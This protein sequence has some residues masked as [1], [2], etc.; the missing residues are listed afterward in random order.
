MKTKQMFTALF[1]AMLYIGLHAQ[2][3]TPARIKEYGLGFTGLNNYS[4]QYRWGNE[5]RLKRITGFFAGNSSFG[6]QDYVT[7]T[8]SGSTTTSS[9]KVKAPLQTS[10]GLG[11]SILNLKAVVD[12]FGFMYGPSFS[13]SGGYN[14]G[15]DTQPNYYYNNGV[16][17]TTKGKTSY[18]TGNVDIG[19]V[20]GLYYKVSDNFLVYAEISPSVFF[21]YTQQKSEY[22]YYLYNNNTGN[23]ELLK[24]TS[25]TNNNSFGFSGLT[26][27]NAM[28]TLAYRIKR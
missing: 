24:N 1:F 3:A 20:L 17:Q 9:T 6:K 26:N 19:A 27:S 14:L 23:N 18:Y 11:F 22:E 13:I 28:L 15:A 25:T 2:E 5:M 16:L 8:I 12:R 21:Q 10:L 7:G 4:L